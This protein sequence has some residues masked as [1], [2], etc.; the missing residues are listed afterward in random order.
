MNTGTLYSSETLLSQEFE[1]LKPFN[2]ISRQ[3]IERKISTIKR[4][5]RTD[6]EYVLFGFETRRE[7]LLLSRLL[8]GS[9][10]TPVACVI[11]FP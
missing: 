5:D 11:L 3:I 8:V 10:N 9:V 2:N 6:C 7:V 1:S 4:N